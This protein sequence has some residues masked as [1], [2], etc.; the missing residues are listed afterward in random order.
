MN[1]GAEVTRARCSALRVAAAAAGGSGPP[2]AAA[3]RGVFG[4]GGGAVG[5]L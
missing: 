2:I 3:C 1:P 4:D 5:V